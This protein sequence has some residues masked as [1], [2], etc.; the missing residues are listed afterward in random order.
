MEGKFGGYRE[1]ARSGKVLRGQ[2]AISDYYGRDWR[3]IKQLIDRYG[4]PATKIMGQWE[5]HTELID[6]YQMRT[7]AMATGI[8]E[9]KR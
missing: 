1:S 8:E 4:F 3:T 7:V 2:H 5:S 9:E 6:N